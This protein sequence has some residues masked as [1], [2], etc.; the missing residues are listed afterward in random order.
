MRLSGSREGE[1]RG[2]RKGED[3]RVGRR[4]GRERKGEDGREVRRP[5]WREREQRMERGQGILSG[6]RWG[7]E[8][9]KGEE[10]IR[11][12]GNEETRG[13]GKRA[14]DGKATRDLKWKLLR[15]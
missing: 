8:S 13:E 1:E 11:C 15:D 5:E 2:E 4:E 9:E 6:V 10:R 7:E 12:K 14:E 3:G